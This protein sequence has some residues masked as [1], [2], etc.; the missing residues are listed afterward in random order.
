MLANVIDGIP[1][2]VPQCPTTTEIQMP[3]GDLSSHSG[4]QAE[5]PPDGTAYRSC[6][7]CYGKAA[8]RPVRMQR[9]LPVQSGRKCT[10]RSSSAC[11]DQVFGEGVRHYFP[12]HERLPFSTEHLE[13]CLQERHPTSKRIGTEISRVEAENKCQSG[14]TLPRTGKLSHRQKLLCQ[15]T[16]LITDCQ[17]QTGL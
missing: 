13:G 4:L 1:N 15:D 14:R 10:R 11:V 8:Q 12:S 2:S 3:S 6:L 5:E 9:S 17:P 16:P 7:T